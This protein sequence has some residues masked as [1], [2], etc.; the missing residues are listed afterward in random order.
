MY[1][2]IGQSAKEAPVPVSCPPSMVLCR[3]PGIPV[4]EGE[5]YYIDRKRGQS[6]ELCLGRFRLD[7]KKIFFPE[8]VI[9]HWNGLPREVV[10]SLFL[11][12]FKERLDVT[13]RDM[14]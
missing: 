7:I 13:L 8:R 10:E 9:R 6:L 5:L 3:I 11:E 4:G 1:C 12:I 14:F 2:R